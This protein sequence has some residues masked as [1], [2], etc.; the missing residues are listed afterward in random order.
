GWL[1]ELLR[2]K[3]EPSP[4]NRTLWENLSLIRQ[5]LNLSQ[6]ERDVIYDQ[7]SNTGQTFYSEKHTRPLTEQL[8]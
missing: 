3:E 2:W 5:F 6:S 4:Q 7:E 8:Q 1:C